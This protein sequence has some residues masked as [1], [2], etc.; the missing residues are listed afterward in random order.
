MKTNQIGDTM[1]KLLAFLFALATPAFAIDKPIPCEGASCKLK[2]ETR[3]GSNVKVS[4]GNVDGLGKWTIGP[5][6]STEIHVVNGNLSISG[7][8][9]TGN[10]LHQCTRRTNTAASPATSVVASCTGNEIATG[11]GCTFSGSVPGALVD[12]ALLASS[13]Q[14]QW[15]AAAGTSITAIVHCC[16]K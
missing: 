1:K 16:N 15:L 13:H 2:F 10:V 9:G 8:D 4:A 11:G 5:T 6:A 3:D 12:N 14:C 7:T